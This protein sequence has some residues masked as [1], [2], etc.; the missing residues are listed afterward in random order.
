[1]LQAT[2]PVRVKRGLCFVWFQTKKDVIDWVRLFSMVLVSGA[3]TIHAVIYPSF[4]LSVESFRVAFSR[5]I[6]GLF[7]T[8]IDDLDGE[9]KR[10]FVLSMCLFVI[11]HI[12]LSCRY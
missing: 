4:P 11:S 2:F 1:M 5:A 7:L 9:E 8:K 12:V 10:V 6:F 3:V